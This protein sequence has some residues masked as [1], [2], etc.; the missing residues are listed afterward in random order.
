MEL[1]A[2]ISWSG[3]RSLVTGESF[4]AQA[5]GYAAVRAG[6][7]VRFVHADGFFKAMSQAR[8]D[9][10]VGRDL[11]VLPVPRTR[12]SWTTWDSTGLTPQHTAV[13]RTFT[14]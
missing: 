6:H 12:S 9:I 10:S 14:S 8:V 11:P 13:P 2:S 4:L 5:L 7:T 1:T 3:Y